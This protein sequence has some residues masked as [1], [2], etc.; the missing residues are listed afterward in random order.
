MAR[1]GDGIFLRGSRAGSG[2]TPSAI[3]FDMAVREDAVVTM[4]APAPLTP[5]GTLRDAIAACVGA[6][7]S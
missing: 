2:L 4:V 3:L 1:R 5:R 6:G 7:R